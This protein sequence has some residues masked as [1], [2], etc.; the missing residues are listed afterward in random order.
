MIS[1]RHQWRVEHLRQLNDTSFTGHL[2]GHPG[3][4]VRPDRPSDYGKRWRLRPHGM[5]NEDLHDC[6]TI[7]RLTKLPFD[8]EAQ[9]FYVDK[10]RIK[11]ITVALKEAGFLVAL[12]PDTEMSN[13]ILQP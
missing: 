4:D 9:A 10:Q 12:S 13:D 5:T 7:C 3:V 11:A 6:A 8:R 2:A 1:E